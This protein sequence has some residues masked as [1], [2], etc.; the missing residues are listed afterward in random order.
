MELIFALWKWNMMRTFFHLIFI[1]VIFAWKWASSGMICVIINEHPTEY[2]ITQH[3]LDWYR[4][5][6]IDSDIIQLSLQ[7]HS[8]FINITTLLPWSWIQNWMI[9]EGRQ[10]RGCEKSIANINQK[11]GGCDIS[12]CRRWMRV[13]ESEILT[14]LYMWV[15]L[16]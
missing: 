3:A 13:S 15:S 12:S 2:K 11:L 14:N 8:N 1:M 4:L 7:F 5:G 9:N 16:V 10:E 6:W